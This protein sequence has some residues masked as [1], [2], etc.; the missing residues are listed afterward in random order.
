[1]RRR[2]RQQGEDDVRRIRNRLARIAAL[3]ALLIALSLA[4]SAPAL[5][6]GGEG[7]DT[8]D[9]AQSIDDGGVPQ[10]E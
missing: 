8:L 4:S 5:G 10:P 7:F 9:G 6:W 3:V 1:M 2:D